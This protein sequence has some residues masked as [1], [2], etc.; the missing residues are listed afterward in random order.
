MNTTAT[1][2]YMISTP[3]PLW[4]HQK[5][6]ISALLAFCAVNSP[7]TSEF[8]SQR[9]VTRSFDVF[10]DLC[11]KNRLSKQSRRR[12]LEPPSRSLWRYCNDRSPRREVEHWLCFGFTKGFSAEIWSVHWVRFGRNGRCQKYN[13]AVLRGVH[14]LATSGP[15]TNMV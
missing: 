6:T 15:F 10:F 14:L 4:R 1:I 7:V 13:S 9:P 11:L 12:W 8:P 2:M 5:G 3:T